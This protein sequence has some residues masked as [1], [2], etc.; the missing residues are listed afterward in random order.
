MLRG[1]PACQLHSGR[2]PGSIRGSP[3]VLGL[4]LCCLGMG[5][6][7]PTLSSDKSLHLRLPIPTDPTVAPRPPGRRRREGAPIA[8]QG[9]CGS[10]RW[11]ALRSKLQKAPADCPAQARST[12]S[13]PGF[14]VRMP[15]SLPDARMPS[16]PPSPRCSSQTPPPLFPRLQPPWFPQS[17]DQLPASREGRSLTVPE[18]LGVRMSPRHMPTDQTH[19][20]THIV[21]RPHMRPCA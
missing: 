2:P 12:V 9:L 6:P 10:R 5:P 17:K 13:E 8:S 19:T 14:P 4:K 1:Y 20:H 16:L 18:R 11:L 3:E 15:G 7:P 21:H